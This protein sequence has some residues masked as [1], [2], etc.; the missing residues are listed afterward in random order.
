[1]EG[2]YFGWMQVM[3]LRMI[4]RRRGEKWRIWVCLESVWVGLYPCES[5]SFM[6]VIQADMGRWTHPGTVAYLSLPPSIMDGNNCNGAM[7]AVNS[8]H[9]DAMNKIIRPVR[10][11]PSCNVVGVKYWLIPQYIECVKTRECVAPLGSNRSN[12]RQDQA[13]LSALIHL[14]GYRC[15]SHAPIRM[16]GD[17]PGDGSKFCQDENGN[18]GEC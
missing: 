8:Q 16:G 12:H 17:A 2:W 5:L 7:W 15:D 1:M 13:A 6:M 10:L 9:F 3:K 18:W 14:H 4:L 11:L